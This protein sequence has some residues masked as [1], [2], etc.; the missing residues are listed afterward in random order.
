MHEL[1][2][3]SRF[4]PMDFRVSMLCAQK[5]VLCVFR[6]RCAATELLVCKAMSC[7]N[8][9]QPTRIL[10]SLPCWCL[11]LHFGA[12]KLQ[13]KYNYCCSCLQ[14]FELKN[15]AIKFQSSGE[16]IEITPLKLP[17][18]F[19]NIIMPTASH[20]MGCPQ[21]TTH[22]MAKA[23]PR[24][25]TGQC[26]GDICQNKAWAQVRPCA[27]QQSKS[28]QTYLH[29]LQSARASAPLSHGNLNGS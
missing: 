29:T 4:L 21:Q 16:A 20:G 13:K 25:T 6:Y 5:H 27:S 10:K 2:H 17:Y 28:D 24:K 7:R 9:L 14:P 11:Q 23:G 8:A 12:C 3:G 22:G 15:C 1:G 19:I 18:W 26:D